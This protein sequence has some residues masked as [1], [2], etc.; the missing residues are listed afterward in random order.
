MGS[1]EDSDQA[2]VGA[3]VFQHA[4]WQRRPVGGAAADEA[5]HPC[6]ADDGGIAGV[7]A[8]D[9]RTGGAPEAAIVVLPV[10]EVVVAV[11]IGAQRRVVVLRGQLSGA[12]LGQ[13]P[14]IFA[15]RSASSWALEVFARRYWRQAATLV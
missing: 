2:P 6:V 13:R 4:L 12:P 8:P 3:V 9:V 11:R 10:Q 1:D 7:D 15:A 5:V 14:T